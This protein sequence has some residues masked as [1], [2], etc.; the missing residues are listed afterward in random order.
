ML[1]ITEEQFQKV[2]ARDTDNFVAAVADEFLADR[3]DLLAQ[4]GRAEIIGR[5]RAA[6]DNGLNLGFTQTPSLIYMMYMSA[7]LPGIFQQPE[8]QQYLTKPGA[9]PEQR[10][11]DMKDV[12][13][14]FA[15]TSGQEEE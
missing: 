6:Y 10:L 7:D 12:L 2:Q 3:P 11:K 13:R 1:K 4:P 15:R 5:M 8:T 14:Y 9:T